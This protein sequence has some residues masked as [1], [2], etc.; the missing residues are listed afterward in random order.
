MIKQDEINALLANEIRKSGLNDVIKLDMVKEKVMK[1]IQ[2]M[3]KDLTEMENPAIAQGPTIFP[4][5]AEDEEKFK[6]APDIK[7]NNM[8]IP[9]NGME[10]GSQ[11]L[12]VP[13]EP[14]LAIS[15][16]TPDFL[17]NVEPG[18]LFVYDFNELS[19]GG[20]NLSN[21]P[22]KTMD[23]PN[24]CKSMQQMWSENGITKAEVYQTKFEKIG[25]ISF[26]YK[27]GASQFI[28]KGA[29]P[30]FNI[31]Q[32]YKENPYAAD[33]G[34]EVETYVK[35]NINLDQKVTDVITDIVKNYFLTNSERAVN[36][37]VKVGNGDE[38]RGL[39]AIKPNAEY[40]N[41]ND[42]F[43]IRTDDIYKSIQEEK[44]TIKDL[45]D[46]FQKIETPQD[47]KETLEGKKKTAKLV[48]ED[49]E[50]KKFV[51]NDKEYYL[52]SNPMSIRMCYVK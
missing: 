52:P 2:E 50:I 14:K 31:Q 6:V 15:P 1:K 40:I 25:E 5:P 29:D 41:P 30:D 11:P 39:G 44:L 16:E 8:E 27:S 46:K 9:K 32:Q 21:K 20:E 23:N 4:N 48:Y 36:E 19:V 28:Q 17:K 51:L 37:P 18:K 24:I 3:S 26:D 10:A 13:I 42:P 12:E 35:N 47:L 49:K 38:T 43:P 45:V 7:Q 34:K 33:P 22:F